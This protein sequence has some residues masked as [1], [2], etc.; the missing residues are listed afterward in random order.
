MNKP[1]HH[2]FVCASFRAGGDPK[3]ICH[4]KG[5]T[6]FLAYIENELTDRGMSDVLV[7]SCGCLKACD[8]GPVLIVYP[9][10]QW[11]GNI[12]GED[13]IDDILDAMEENRSAEDHLIA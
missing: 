4:K 9:E 7:S 6:D 2:I 10:N 11:Y 1:Q 5:G 12:A 8:H 3:G 13:A